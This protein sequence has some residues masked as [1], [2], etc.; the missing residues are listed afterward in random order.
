MDL[1]EHIEGKRYLGREFLAFLWFESELFEGTL[2]LEGRGSFGLWLESQLTLDG[3]LQS[4]EQC[5]LR[6]AS[7]SGSAEAHEA[8]R[9]GKLPTTARVRIDLGE[10]SFAFLL[11]AET[12][13][14]GSVK[15]PAVL[16][17]E[18]DEDEPFYERMRLLEELESLVDGLYKDFVSLRLSDR[19]DGELLPLLRRWVQ[20]EEVDA[21]VYRRV[22][23]PPRSKKG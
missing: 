4:K 1:I 9:Q 16:G 18:K 15:L 5:K 20:G 7:P 8:L 23:R 2:E 11:H 17:E 12:L 10:Q 21:E 6:G 14:L 19:W 22:R 3:P 13:R